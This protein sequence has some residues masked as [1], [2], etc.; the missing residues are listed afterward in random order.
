LNRRALLLVITGIVAAIAATVVIFFLITNLRT[1]VVDDSPPPPGTPTVRR[2]V[3]VAAT[4]IL[5]STEITFS[6][7]TTGVYPIETI[8]ND[9]LTVIT[10]VVGRQAT[11]HIFSGQQLLRRHVTEVGDVSKTSSQIPPG[12]VL[13]AFPST[14]MLNATGAVQAMDFVD[15]MISIPISGTTRLDAAADSGTQLET[16]ERALVAQ[17]TLQNI[18]V[19]SVGTW[20]PTGQQAATGANATLKI[21]TFVVDPQEALILK[22]VKDSGGTIDL[23]VRSSRD[24]DIKDTDPVTLDYL[25][26][27]FGFIGLNQPSP[28]AQPAPAPTPAP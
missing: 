8:Q 27:L 14:D 28:P 21:I 2:E 9:A 17:M 6:Q 26:D 12:K 13:V 1:T 19:R 3:V 4:D 11:T 22:F 15:I 5:P 20:S 18:E 24:K 25:V 23:A 7:V 10:D 16:G